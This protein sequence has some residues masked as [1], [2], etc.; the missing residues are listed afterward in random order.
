MSGNVSACYDVI[1]NRKGA[2]M[3]RSVLG[4]MVVA[5]IAGVLNAEEL[6]VPPGCRAKEGTIA[7]P[8]TGTGWAKERTV[9]L[10]QA[11]PPWT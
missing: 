11:T 2:M 1:I 7:D 10:L 4:G 6:R 3:R 8:Y 9:F 5:L